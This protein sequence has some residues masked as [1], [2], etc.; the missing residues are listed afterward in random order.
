MS[1]GSLT[2]MT[3][4]STKNPGF[5]CWKHKI[6]TFLSQTVILTKVSS[7]HVECSFEDTSEFFCRQPEKH[8]LNVRKRREKVFLI[9]NSFFVQNS[10]LQFMKP[11]LA[12]PAKKSSPNIQK[13][14][15]DSPKKI[16]K[17]FD[18]AFFSKRILWT[19]EVQF[20]Q[21]SLEVFTINQKPFLLEVRECEAQIPNK[22]TPKT[23]FWVCK[24]PFWRFLCK[25]NSSQKVRNILLG[26]RKLRRY[27]TFQER[28]FLELVDQIRKTQFWRLCLE[29]LCERLKKSLP[30]SRKGKIIPSSQGPVLSNI[31][32]SGHVKGSFRH[33]CKNIPPKV[34]KFSAEKPKVILTEAR[35]SLAESR[36]WM[37]KKFYSKKKSFCPK[38]LLWSRGNQFRQSNQKLRQNSGTFSLT[39]QKQRNGL[40]FRKMFFSYSIFW[41]SKIQLWQPYRKF[42]RNTSA[43]FIAW[44]AWMWSPDSKE[45][46]HPKTS[47]CALEMHLSKTCLILFSQSPNTFARS[48]GKWK[49]RKRFL[50]ISRNSSSR[51]VECRSDS[52]A[53]NFLEN[54]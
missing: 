10:P 8:Q 35:E 40:K 36:K 52:S 18:K 53:E 29:F 15:A 14:F 42:S 27:I 24:K 7:G 32:S 48:L 4:F 17:V 11:I 5:Y 21:P 22:I 46:F 41:T 34:R 44:N 43:I 39:V 12:K 31:S 25:L 23:S 47:F 19:R 3:D 33:P 49:N 51:Y 54:F 6:E 28:V 16:D 30:K 45:K 1:K 37:K 2:T 9:R 38:N 13:V 26:F 20:W 50:K